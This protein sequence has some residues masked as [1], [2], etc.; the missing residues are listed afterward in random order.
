MNI[1]NA[2]RGAAVATLALAS[3]VAPAF[4]ETK[5]DLVWSHP[6]E[7]PNWNY[8]Q[9]GASALTVP[10]F[11]NV[12]QPLVEKLG[13]GTVAPLLAESWEISDD[14]LEYT[15][16]LRE[17]KFHDG[18]D[19]D[20][21]DVVYSLK[22]N[23]ESPQAKTNTPLRPVVTIEAVDDRTVKLV[24]SQPSQRLLGELGLMSGIV[25]PD[26]AHEALDLNSEMIGTGPYVFGEYRPDV[27]LILD[28]FEDY[29]GDKPF[30]EKVT[31]RFIPDETAAI[32]AL[33]AG[34][35]DMVVSVFGEGLDRLSAFDSDDRFKVIVPDPFETNYMFL[36]T[37]VESLRDIRVRQ[38]I[39]HGIRRDDY[40][41]GAQSGYGK[42]TC[43]WVVPFSE[44][45]NNDYCPYPYDPE[46]SRELLK[47]AGQEGLELDFPFITVAEHPVIK[48]IVVA[49]LAEV[50]ITLNARAL[51]LAT[52]LEQVNRN[53]DYEFSNL[54]SNVTAES[55]VCGGGRQPLGR[56]DTVECDTE[57][58]DLV[59]RSDSVL[60]ADEYIETMAAMTARF[61]ESAWVIPIHAKS[62]PTLTR[63][64]L[65][66]HKPYRFR[67]E[68]DLRNLRWAE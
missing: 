66:G 15:F 46:K 16:H 49:Q 20:A 5:T 44:P 26:G 58:D 65:V 41:Y 47:E 28:R 25:V 60:D 18:T 9:T 63:A 11:L 10:T 14:G 37:N 52:W 43:Q 8:W 13:D 12:L 2:L 57:F 67:I 27:H 24:L 3:V 64:D 17:A 34:E 45:W 23:Q 19:L 39:A 22:K 40:L 32:N 51:D 53:G 33:L 30:F 4:A 21:G 36:S 42:T 56:P 50:G 6:Q 35:L 61:A 38:A 48:D 68:M 31:H 55:F 1:L 62:T 54:T 29:W 7:P 59:A